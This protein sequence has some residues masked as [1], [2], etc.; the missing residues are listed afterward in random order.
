MKDYQKRVLSEQKELSLK[1]VSLTTF[2]TEKNNLVKIT[3]MEYETLYEQ[4]NIM[5]KYNF[6]L[7]TRINYFKGVS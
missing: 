5:L 7:L 6:I 4:L 3:N 2:I 1:I